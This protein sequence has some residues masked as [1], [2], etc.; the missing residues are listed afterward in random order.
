MQA[1]CFALYFIIVNVLLYI[2]APYLAILVVQKVDAALGLD[3]VLP[4]LN[5]RFLSFFSPLF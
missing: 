4:H 3:S 1:K 5:L 2:V